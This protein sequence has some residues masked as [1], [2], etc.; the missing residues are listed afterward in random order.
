MSVFF[1]CLALLLSGKSWYSIPM[2][3]QSAPPE[4]LE[5]VRTK[6][7]DHLMDSNTLLEFHPLFYGYQEIVDNPYENN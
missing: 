5:I 1:W 2:E 3:N 4:T 6:W 7:L